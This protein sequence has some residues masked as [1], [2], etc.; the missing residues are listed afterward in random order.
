MTVLPCVAELSFF[1]K[2]RYSIIKKLF[3]SPKGTAKALFS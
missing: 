3:K 1:Y 2:H